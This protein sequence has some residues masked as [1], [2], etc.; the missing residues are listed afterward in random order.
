MPRKSFAALAAPTPIPYAK[1]RLAAP[2]G[3]NPAA[4]GI[5]RQI[6]T[7]LP[8]GYFGS[9]TGLLLERLCIHLDR[10]RRFE[11]LI[12]EA[13][14]AP[15]LDLDLFDRLA[16][17]ARAESAAAASLARALRLTI[18]SR[19]P[20]TAGRQAAMPAPTLGIEALTMVRHGQD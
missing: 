18:Q 15:E 4:S 16:K 2:C 6:V 12:A 19:H 8:P 11:A 7:E 10:C 13:E 1:P 14:A 17:A 3:L 20:V 5:W 9:D